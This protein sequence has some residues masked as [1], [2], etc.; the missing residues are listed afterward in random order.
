[1]QHTVYIKNTYYKINCKIDHVQ[2][3][4]QLHSMM[5]GTNKVLKTITGVIQLLLNS[6]KSLFYYFKLTIE[7]CKLLLN[8]NLRLTHAYHLAYYSY[9]TILH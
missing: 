5:M 7:Q 9:I 4:I 6:Y 3:Q 1:M 2:Y 8:D